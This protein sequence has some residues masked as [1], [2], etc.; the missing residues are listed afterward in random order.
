[1]CTTLFCKCYNLVDAQDND[2]PVEP[3]YPLEKRSITNINC[4]HFSAYASDCAMNAAAMYNSNKKS[5]PMPNKIHD[6]C[7]AIKYLTS[8]AM[9]WNTDCRE[10][11]D[12]HFNEESLNGHSYV[13]HNICED[14]EFINRYMN[15]SECVANTSDQ[16]EQ[17]YTS[18]KSLV[19]GFK[20]N[21][22]TDWTHYETHFYLCCGRAKFRR[23]VL[24][25]AF[26]KTYNCS[27]HQAVTLQ[28]FSVIV[29]E[30]DVYQDCDFNMI[31]N[32]CPGGD[33]RP[34]HNDLGLIQLD[35][36]DFRA[37]EEQPILQLEQ[38]PPRG[39]D[40]PLN[41]SGLTKYANWL[42]MLLVIFAMLYSNILL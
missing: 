9:D 13:V 23:C 24:D 33:P 31:Y 37:L 8:C 39:V 28:K 36:Q 16:W 11:T 27:F 18:F 25:V 32:N 19:D 2:E 15:T 38:E 29:S 10:V 22:T 41:G 6:W 1:M 21:T 3:Q 42:Y 17:C 40:M 35:D 26:N 12:S 4:E 5:P 30:G 14:K 34:P 7:R 20:K